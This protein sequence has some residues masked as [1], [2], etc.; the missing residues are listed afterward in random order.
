M[1]DTTICDSPTGERGPATI[2]YTDLL[3]LS[4]HSVSIKLA[5]GVSNE[6][7]LIVDLGAKL[8]DIL[9]R[10][11][12][13]TKSLLS[14]LRKQDP[15]ISWTGVVEWGKYATSEPHSSQRANK[16]CQTATPRVTAPVHKSHSSASKG[17]WPYSQ[18]GIYRD[19]AQLRLARPGRY[20]ES[21]DC[22]LADQLLSS[23]GIL[24]QVAASFLAHFCSANNVKSH[25][26]LYDSDST[27]LDAF[28]Y[29]TGAPARTR[30]V[31]GE[32]VTVHPC[33]A[34]VDTGLVTVVVDDC[35]GL[36]V[37][38]PTKDQWQKV[39]MTPNQV[40]VL[41]NRDLVALLRGEQS[42]AP[43]RY[44]VTRP[45]T[46]AD[47]GVKDGRL[48]LTYEIRT[49]PAGAQRI[50]GDVKGKSGQQKRGEAAGKGQCAIC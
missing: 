34:H 28:H 11:M 36:E 47:S 50:N 19:R 49:S 27:V 29:P 17:V 45:D 21:V 1:S 42:L 32:T 9:R 44:R 30:V 43:T 22:V 14:Y 23:S 2:M 7:F 20:S 39:I 24:H 4:E 18:V 16:D 12:P 8:A 3:R 25:E 13:A 10:P 35:P 6:G 46:A 33:P 31:G 48:C 37:Y 38:L 40:A 5:E 41:V 26:E 15:G